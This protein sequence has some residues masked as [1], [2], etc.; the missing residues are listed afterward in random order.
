MFNCF[1]YYSSP[2]SIYFILATEYQRVLQYMTSYQLFI[3]GV[4]FN[5]KQWLMFCYYCTLLHW[6]YLAQFHR[7]S[8]IFKKQKNLVSIYNS[9]SCFL[10][11]FFSPLLIQLTFLQLWTVTVARNL[12]YTCIRVWCIR[13]IAKAVSNWTFGT[14]DRGSP[15]SLSSL[16]AWL[17]VLRLLPRVLPNGS[18]IWQN[19]RQRSRGWG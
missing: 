10:S 1:L 9:K 8:Q 13:G 2:S 14:K 19:C 16:Q 6:A 12:Q 15:N 4:V 11:I 5:T 18:C 17:K 3:S 7:N